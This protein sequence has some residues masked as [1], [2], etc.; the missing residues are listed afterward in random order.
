M[1]ISNCQK[2]T[3]GKRQLAILAECGGLLRSEEGAE[4]TAYLGDSLIPRV[5]ACN[6]ESRVDRLRGAVG[7]RLPDHLDK[8][9]ELVS[10]KTGAIISY[11]SNPETLLDELERIYKEQILPDYLRTIEGHNPDGVLDT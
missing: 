10:K 1:T 4:D 9:I 2:I 7:Q 11:H 8:I 3:L 6:S 5:V